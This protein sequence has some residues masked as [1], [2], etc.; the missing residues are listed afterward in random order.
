MGAMAYV[1]YLL[2]EI[3]RDRSLMWLKRA[4]GLGDTSA[5]SWL[6]YL[7]SKSDRKAA[8]EWY[9]RAA[10]GG[11]PDAM[12]RL[13]LLIRKHRP[14]E[15]RA[16]IEKAAGLGHPASMH[17]LGHLLLRRQRRRQALNM[18]ERAAK[19]GDARAM[20]DMSTM[21]KVRRMFSLPGRRRRRDDGT[22]W[23][24]RAAEA[25]NVE[26]MWNMALDCS[27]R[28]DQQGRDRW[29]QEAADKGHVPSKF[30]L[31]RKM[32]GRTVLSLLRFFRLRS[33]SQFHWGI[34]DHFSV[35]ESSPAPHD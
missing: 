30:L 6:G 27:A 28:D 10:E 33:Y 26:A 14:A 19:A 18:F 17:S 13:G 1:G 4:A 25:G 2:R 15:A 8:A 31:Y 29:L 35:P 9:R 7:L 5:M 23:L 22:S 32:N 24:A 3:D 11:D 12:L 20:M 16:W 21:L 34:G